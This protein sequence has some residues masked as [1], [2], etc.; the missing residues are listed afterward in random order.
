MANARSYI[1]CANTNSPQSY[2]V[3]VLLALI[4][5]SVTQQRSRSLDDVVVYPGD[6]LRE[7]KHYFQRE[8]YQTEGEN[9]PSNRAKWAREKLARRKDHFLHDLTK[10]IV[11]RCVSHSVGTLVIGDPSGVDESDWGR[12]GNKRL[13]DWT[14]GR[15][16]VQADDEPT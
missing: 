11:E 7:D 15:L 8:E 13:D 10:D 1:S 9:G 12:H 3:T 5:V 2:R 14:T 4:S 6:R 16:G